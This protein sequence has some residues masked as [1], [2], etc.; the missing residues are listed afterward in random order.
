MR[1]LPRRGGPDRRLRRRDRR[2]RRR[3]G[4]QL[5]PA[6]PGPPLPARRRQV[7][8]H[9]AR[10]PRRAAAHR[11]G[12]RGRAAEARERH[13]Q[14][15]AR[16]RAHVTDRA[17]GADQEGCGG[18]SPTAGIASMRPFGRVRRRPCGHRY[19]R[20]GD[21]VHGFVIFPLIQAARHL[22]DG[23]V[24]GCRGY[25]GGMRSTQGLPAR[26]LTSMPEATDRVVR[27]AVEAPPGHGRL[28]GVEVDSYGQEV[29]AH[30]ADGGR[31]HRRHPALAA[32]VC[33]RPA[34]RGPCRCASGGR[35]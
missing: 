27:G 26:P 2:H 15:V 10:Q 11:R 30:E 23:S 16:A 8:D 28:V 25:A 5:R 34:A 6:V 18:R 12:D 33:R 13:R 9:P 32:R 21:P 7:R 1:A 17:A 20:A 22:R 3:R 4:A 31:G 14:P 19:S 29:G 24:S 35:S